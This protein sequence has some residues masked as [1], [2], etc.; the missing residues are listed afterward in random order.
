M[1]DCDHAPAGF[2]HANRIRS[3]PPTEMQNDTCGAAPGPCRNSSVLVTGAGGSI[4]AELCRQILRARP[5]RLILLDQSEYALYTIDRELSV[6]AEGRGV[7]VRPVLGS[8]A[9]AVA[10]QGL[11]RQ[12]RIDLVLHAAAYKHVP[13]V[14]ANPLAGVAANVIGTDVIA[15]AAQAGGVPRFVLVSSDKAVRPANVM[16]ATKRLAEMVVQD[17]AARPGPT[18][19]SAVRFG[20]VLGSSGSVA[21]LFA[22]QIARGGPVTVTAEEATRYF[23]TLEEAAGLVLQ[24]AALARGGEIFLRDMGRPVRVGDLARQM[25]AAAGHHVRRPGDT[26]GIDIVTTGLRPGEK[27]HEELLI[28]GK[29]RPTPVPGI[30]AADEACPSEIELAAI[31]RS[32]REAVMQD[33]P[34]RARQVFC[35]WVEGYG[36]AATSTRRE[37]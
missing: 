10:M 2:D 22:A 6:F 28:G 16:G 13:L 1:N 27:L 11:F 9:N 20:N 17:L 32:L 14:E 5:A 23:M 30:F 24:A 21:P 29:I 4:G 31:L 36:A 26:G 35:R 8:V 19:F 18:V 15:R 12:E 3:G 25:I 37:A 7:T 34:A 33:D